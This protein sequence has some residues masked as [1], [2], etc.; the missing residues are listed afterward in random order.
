MVEGSFAQL[1][2]AN[3]PVLRGSVPRTGAAD[4]LHHPWKNRDFQMLVDQAKSTDEPGFTDVVFFLY[5]LAGNGA[6]GVIKVLKLLKRKSATD[7]QSH[8]ARIPLS[9]G[10]GGITILS[11]PSSPLVLE[12]KLP[13]KKDRQE[14][15]L[16][17][18]EWEKIQVLPRSALIQIAQHAPRYPTWFDPP[19]PCRIDSIFHG[20]SHPH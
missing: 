7:H 12:R 2:D 14:P 11:E 18:Q 5:D 9:E 10:N 1:V 4:K 19:F 16:S 20:R 15:A 13:R 8:D 17:M 3:F 6:D